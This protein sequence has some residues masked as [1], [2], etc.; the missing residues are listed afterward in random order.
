MVEFIK[1]IRNN[2]L[3]AINTLA[4][5]FFVI[6]QFFFEG[7]RI[8]ITISCVLMVFLIL[9]IFTRNLWNESM[10]YVVVI[11]AVVPLVIV[12]FVSLFFSFIYYPNIDFSIK[13]NMDNFSVKWLLIFISFNCLYFSAHTFTMKKSIKTCREE[14]KVYREKYLNKIK[15]ATGYV[16]PLFTLLG[17]AVKLL[18]QSFNYKLSDSVLILALL[19]IIGIINAQRAWIDGMIYKIKFLQERNDRVNLG[20]LIIKI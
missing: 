10:A 20:R 3:I 7:T 15:T 11:Y 2:L 19:I 6:L 17:V 18:D 13:S 16:V 4:M 5:I 1:V 12:G 8:P 9:W 14:D